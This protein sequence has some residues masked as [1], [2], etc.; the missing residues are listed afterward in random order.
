MFRDSNITPGQLYSTTSYQNHD[1]TGIGL[2]GTHLAGIRLSGF[3]LTNASFSHAALNNADLSGANLTNS[4]F[5]SATLTGA[6]FAG[7]DA[8]GAH[9]DFTTPGGFTD[10]QFYARAATRRMI[11]PESDQTPILRSMAST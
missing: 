3:N 11:C 1:L 9:F 4:G 5:A 10:P 7:S 6:N 2:D 8:R